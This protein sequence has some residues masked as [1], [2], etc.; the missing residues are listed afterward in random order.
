M[1]LV[2]LASE[3]IAPLPQSTDVRICILALPTV[4]EGDK[5]SMSVREALGGKLVGSS[6]KGVR[7]EL[8]PPN[9]KLTI[10]LNEKT[11]EWFKEGDVTEQTRVK[12]LTGTLLHEN[13]AG[14]SYEWS[15]Y[16]DVRFRFSVGYSNKRT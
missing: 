2:N 10:W 14:V 15:G 8:D 7:F 1:T 13:A 9:G 6:T 12:T 5:C 4:A 16:L 11:A 3:D